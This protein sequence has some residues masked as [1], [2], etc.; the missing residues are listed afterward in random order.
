MTYSTYAQMGDR[1]VKVWDIGVRLFHW[2]LVASVIFAYFTEDFRSLHR[3]VGYAVV[4]LV[5]FRLIWGLIGTRHARFTSFVPGP[6]RL[7]AYLRDILRGTEA[8]Y[9]GHNPAGAAMILGLLAMLIGV[10]VT[11]HMMGMNAYFGQ[12]WVEELHET[13]VNLLLVMI[14]LHVAGVALSSR[15]HKENLVS[16]MVTGE[17]RVD[18]NECK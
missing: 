9:L 16:A 4:A 17:K 12:D 6:F 18:D 14:A 15:R 5:G 7:F 2:S 13:L 10:G 1:T 3:W 11:G 8:R